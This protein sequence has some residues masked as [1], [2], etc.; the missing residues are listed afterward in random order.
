MCDLKLR[1]ISLGFGDER[2]LLGRTG[3]GVSDKAR[4]LKNAATFFET[5]IRASHTRRALFFLGF[6]FDVQH[7]FLEH[8]LFPPFPDVKQ[9]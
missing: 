4:D 9:L 6:L 7:N 8:N 1:S 5:G 3:P 2:Y